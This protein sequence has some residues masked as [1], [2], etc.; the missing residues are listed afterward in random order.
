MFLPFGHVGFMAISECYPIGFD[1]PGVLPGSPIERLH[2]IRSQRAEAR[3]ALQ[4]V[5]YAGQM[6][7]LFGDTKW[8]EYV[9]EQTRDTTIEAR[10]RATWAKVALEIAKLGAADDTPPA[11]AQ[12]INILLDP[13]RARGLAK[14]IAGAA[15]IDD[16]DGQVI[17]IKPQKRRRKTAKKRKSNNDNAD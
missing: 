17:D 14:R 2:T 15:V 10:A 16:P 3:N 6:L 11:I 1:E 5:K 7:D 4:R 12:Q 13:E 9:L 8:I